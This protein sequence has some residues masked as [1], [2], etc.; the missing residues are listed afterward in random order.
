MGNDTEL[1][2]FRK[3]LALLTLLNF[4]YPLQ[5]NNAEKNEK[6]GRLVEA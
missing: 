3:R 6:T 1:V 4:I 5:L 2:S